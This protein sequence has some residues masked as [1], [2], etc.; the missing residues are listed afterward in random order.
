MSGKK[1]KQ[2][3]VVAYIR[4]RLEGA[5]GLFFYIM[6][7]SLVCSAITV[8]IPIF[9]KIFL[10][11]ILSGKNPEWLVPLISIM[12]GV[13]VFQFFSESIQAYYWNMVK[14][15]MTVQANVEFMWHVLRL[16]VSYFDSRLVGDIAARQASN[17]K[18]ASSLVSRFAPVV[19]NIGMLALYL[20][21]MISYSLPLALIGVAA[22]ILNVVSMRT[23][24]KKRVEL[25][26][27]VEQNEGTL[28]GV[29]SSSLDMIESIKAA[30][31]EH[32]FFERWSNAYTRTHNS[33][34]RFEKM[35]E[36]FSVIPTFLQQIANAAIL[37]LGTLLIIDGKL[38]I[39]MLMAFQ[40]FFSSF[41]SPV[42]KLVKS[43]SAF[44][45][46]RTQM[47]RVDDVLSYEPDVP[48]QDDMPYEE[49]K[50]E[51]TLDHVKFGYVP[52]EEPLIKDFSMH[53]ERGKSVAFVG[54]SGTGKST[55]VK[56]IA[57][58]Y[59]I[60]DGE[61]RIDGKNINDI[62]R[63]SRT[64]HIAVVDQDISLFEDTIANNIT[65]WDHSIPL[66]DV[67]D[68][69]KAAGIHDEIT[70]RPGGYEHM[71]R[72]GGG[73]FSGGQRQRMEIAR[74]LVRKPGVLI[75]DEA[76]SALDNA[77][78]QQV[79][80]NVKQMGVTTIVIAHRLSTIRDC[81]EIIVLEDGQAVER[82]N[83][84]SLMDLEGRY[85]QLVKGV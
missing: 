67:V 25:S 77:T 53:V 13:A 27:V 63:K 12:V 14:G 22:V 85:A 73:N 42:N 44:V 51:V 6:L 46:M 33:R 79:M 64:D 32:G 17:E 49:L 76:T 3:S 50:G 60:W 52:S 36:Y 57:G 43:A 24:S 37:V 19:V 2:P 75:L 21:I 5:M 69:C 68:A 84:K 29:T 11:N 66:G 45:E 61:I 9:S 48:S 4:R 18:I 62:S 83:H 78:E 55:L 74:A 34:V 31:A 70:L 41:I 7:W 26:R 81:D 38:T 56:L 8:I 47:E 82:G 23:V 1:E 28:S 10:D 15:R 65:M 16:P 72:D 39:G 59:P 71:V 30:A 20:V 58:L 54:A 80:E 40:G 35:D